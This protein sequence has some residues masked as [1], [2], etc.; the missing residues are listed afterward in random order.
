ML[1]EPRLK[2]CERRIRKPAFG[3]FSHASSEFSCDNSGRVDGWM[4]EMG[5][6][7]CVGDSTASYSASVFTEFQL[8]GKGKDGVN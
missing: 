8:P 5:V 7:A 4:R 3:E 6:R 2:P 1:T